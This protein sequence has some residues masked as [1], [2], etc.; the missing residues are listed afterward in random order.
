MIITK[1]TSLKYNGYHWL[2]VVLIIGLILLFIVGPLDIVNKASVSDSNCGGSSTLSITWDAMLEFNEPGLCYGYVTFGEAP[3][4]NDGPPVDIHDVMLPPAPMPPYIRSWFNDGLPAPH[5]KLWSDYRQYPDTY[6][7]WDL[8][9][10]WVPDDMVSPTDITIS[11]DIAEIGA[12]E[13][14][15]VV[16][17]DVTGG[18]V[19]ADML[20]DTDYTF[21]AS[22]M[23]PKAFQIICS[24]NE[25]PVFSDENPSNESVN[26]PITTSQL[27][28]SIR[29]P[30]GDSFD[31]SIE[32][33]PDIGSSNGVGESN[34]TKIC[35][36][37]GLD[38]D[39]TYA[40]YVNATDSGSGTAR[41][42]VYT[43][44]TT[45]DPGGG[46]TPGGGGSPPTN[47]N[48]IA[49][50]SAGEPYT[51]YIGEE[52]TFNGSL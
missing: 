27:T 24:L 4:A 23:I 10:Q 47:Q 11:W 25:P 16:L 40:W 28:V 38:Y 41:E 2:K 1:N 20:V 36:V 35:S 29:N 50:A 34:G 37:G 18:T 39:T 43:F 12:S 30:E 5:N 42:D 19:V 17:Y 51:G 9:V 52:I 31:W 21:N 48:P 15:D 7:L 44:T 22:A 49:N 33:I 14:D 13:Y 26:V 6:K 3:D 46:G 45:G 8:G 32:T